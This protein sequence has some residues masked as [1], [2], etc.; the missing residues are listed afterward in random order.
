[1]KICNME[2]R[3]WRGNREPDKT[4]SGRDRSCQPAW[5]PLPRPYKAASPSVPHSQQPATGLTILGTTCRN[6]HLR[7]HGLTGRVISQQVDWQAVE[8]SIPSTRGV[9][10]EEPALSKEC[11]HN[12]VA[13]GVDGLGGRICITVQDEGKISLGFF[14]IPSEGWLENDRGLLLFWKCV[15]VVYFM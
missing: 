11:P 6:P 14:R 12:P 4:C 15:I 3:C 13:L 1:M 8:S 9:C 7:G 2:Q 10:R 5:S